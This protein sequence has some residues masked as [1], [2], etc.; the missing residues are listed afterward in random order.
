M[1]EREL[2]RMAEEER[3]A[4]VA[5][6]RRRLAGV[7]EAEDAVQ[8]ALVKALR[9]L[10][11]GSRPDNGRAWLFTILA[12]CCADVRT[13]AARRP[14]VPVLEGH[15]VEDAAPSVSSTAEAR[16]EVASAVAAIAALPEAQRQALVG[17]ELGGETYEE[18]GARHGWSV[19]AT[20]SLLWRARSRLVQERAGW[21][22]VGSAP[23]AAFRSLLG[24][25][26]KPLTAVPWGAE[27]LGVAAVAAVGTA[28]VALPERAPAPKHAEARAGHG[29]AAERMLAAAVTARR[30]TAPA[31][32]RGASEHPVTAA[33][34][35][36]ADP[37]AVA[38][39]CAREEPL[40]GR[41]TPGALA[42]AARELPAD[43]LEY[44]TC[45]DAIN[46]TLARGA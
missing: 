33:A 31:V 26:E 37:R 21:A 30:E 23:F 40:A 13:G 2:V 12:H 38:A 8:E 4:L 20:K 39:A 5:F 46:R 43:A 29:K 25:V 35:R 41:F 42:R 28:T 24:H 1:D 45:A 9:A 32:L 19:S 6:A 7:D 17:Y 44:T 36:S 27:V 15:D 18:L 10:R 14:T 16:A 3:A 22:A 34:P 11:S